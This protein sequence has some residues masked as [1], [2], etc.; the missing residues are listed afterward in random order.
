M[1]TL[2]EIIEGG[3]KTDN[4]VVVPPI[5]EEVPKIE[6]IQPAA[7]VEETEKK[8]AGR[9]PKVKEE[10]KIEEVEVIEEKLP[11]GTE[12][13]ETILSKPKKEVDSDESVWADVE[14]LSGEV[15]EV[16]FGGADPNSPEGAFLYAKAYRDKGI[17]EFE[18]GLSQKYPKEY[19]ALLLRMEGKDPSVLYKEDAYDY[20]TLAIKE[21]DEDTQKSILRQDMKSQGLSDKRIDALVKSIYDSGDLY[22]E[23]QDSLK[24]LK[25]KQDQAFAEQQ[26]QIEETK[27]I[28]K[29]EIDQFGGIITEAINKG[30]LGDFVISEKD[31]PG[32][33]D[34]LAK[35]IKYE[36]G[37]FFAVVPLDKDPNVLPKQLQTE[38]FRFKKGNLGELVVKRAITEVSNKLKKN[39]KES[40]KI[41][42]GVSKVQQAAPTWQE[43][44]GLK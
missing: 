39:I 30:Q 36:N 13:L 18:E 37:N 15:I 38:Y 43:K 34:F 3:N 9:L 22:T 32:F 7:T 40:T 44:A 12:S 23:A 29:Q 21:D 25:E 20:K 27:A 17:E 26:R 6:E 31:R 33:Y 19:Q 1:A 14:K 42:E 16:D 10:V 41:G 35:N 2:S 28:Q 8:K 24:R 4:P 11:E 5:I